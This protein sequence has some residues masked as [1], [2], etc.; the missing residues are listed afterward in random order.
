MKQSISIQ[1]CI[2]R[3]AAGW[4]VFAACTVLPGHSADPDVPTR[5]ITSQAVRTP[6]HVVPG[7]YQG[8][9]FFL[10]GLHQTQIT[11]YSPEGRVAL[12]KDLQ[13]GKQRPVSVLGIAIDRDGELAVGWSQLP[14]LSGR[15]AGIDLLDANGRLI[16]SIDTGAY[17]PSHLAFGDEHSVWSFGWERDEHEPQRAADNYMTVRKYSSDGRQVGSFLPRSLFPR[18]LQPACFNW[19][20]RG[21]EVAGDRI[22][23]LACSGMTSEKP[24]WI[25]LDLTGNLLGRWTVEYRRTLTLTRDGHVYAQNTNSKARP[26]LVLDRT[27]STFK[28][29]EFTMPG[30]LYG[31]DGDELVFGDPQVGPIHLRW[32]KQPR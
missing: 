13:D 20:E 30:I 2:L 24:E 26:L 23:V 6:N 15:Y 9:V 17:L 12:V 14:A 7:F 4:I 21:I 11:L 22:G 3:G 27:S 18:G 10:E 1:S 25:E 16:K 8:Y 32:Y 28:N 5:E 31:A 19:Q 29:A